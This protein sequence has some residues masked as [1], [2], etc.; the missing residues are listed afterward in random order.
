MFKELIRI[1]K[2]IKNKNK[3]VFSIEHHFKN[4]RFYP[5]CGF[6]FMI[7]NNLNGNIELV[8]RYFIQ[9]S[10]FFHTKEEAINYINKYKEQESLDRVEEIELN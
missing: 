4:D 7:E 10:I 1:Y 9:Y 6:M 3:N 8:E 5:K 2:S